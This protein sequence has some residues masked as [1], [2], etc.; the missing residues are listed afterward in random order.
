[1]AAPKEALSHVTSR[2]GFSAAGPAEQHPCSSASKIKLEKKEQQPVVE[3]SV[4]KEPIVTSSALEPP[5]ALGRTVSTV[6]SAA[7]AQDKTATERNL[8][9]CRLKKFTNISDVYDISSQVLGTG[10]WR[11]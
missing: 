1:M 8:S 11:Q 4:P 5:V 10:T 9:T 7:P 3:G 6:C 2:E